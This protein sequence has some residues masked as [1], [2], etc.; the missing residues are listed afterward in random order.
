MFCRLYKYKDSYTVS[1]R[2]CTNIR[3]FSIFSIRISNKYSV[4]Q[5]LLKHENS[6][7]QYFR[8]CNISSNIHVSVF[9]LLSTIGL[10]S[11][12]FTRLRRLIIFFL[13]NIKKRLCSKGI[14]V[15]FKILF[16]LC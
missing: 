12:F 15:F 10:F 3:V 16:Y 4:L 14:K 6:A 11:Y 5:I 2:P 9:T 7:I 8:I 1:S 13:I